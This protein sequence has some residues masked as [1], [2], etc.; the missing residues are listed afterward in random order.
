MPS[1]ITAGDLDRL[2]ADMPADTVVLY[3]IDPWSS[4]GSSV[5]WI[6]HDSGQVRVCL[7][8]VSGAGIPVLSSGKGNV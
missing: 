5:R 4:V 3:Q 1:Y 8:P 7:A 6:R 2:F